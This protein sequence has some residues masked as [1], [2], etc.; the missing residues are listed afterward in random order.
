MLHDWDG[1]A[2]QVRAN[3][4]LHWLLSF[5]EVTMVTG[6]S[7]NVWLSQGHRSGSG[8]NLSEAMH[9]IYHPVTAMLA[10]PRAVHGGKNDI[11]SRPAPRRLLLSRIAYPRQ[12]V[13]RK[14]ERASVWAKQGMFGLVPSSKADSR[15]PPDIGLEGR[16]GA[17]GGIEGRTGGRRLVC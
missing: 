5:A 9:K 4:L 8:D 14:P 11:V 16:V 13:L 12:L 3:H 15:Q 6:C 1:N 10:H 2:L 7:S 17:K